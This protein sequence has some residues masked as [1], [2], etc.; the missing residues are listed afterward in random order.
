MTNV[1]ESTFMHAPE[2]AVMHAGFAAEMQSTLVPP[3]T[4]RGAHLEAHGHCVPKEGVGGDLMDLVAEGTDVVAYVGDV[5]GHG[6]RAGVLMGM[7]KTAM[8]Y[9]L[10]LRRA[11]RDLV[12]DLNR[13]LPQVKTPGMYATLAALR[14]DAGDEAEF[15][16]AGHLPLLHFRKQTGDVVRHYAQQPP[17]G[18]LADAVAT[19]ARI[20]IAAG[21]ILLLMSDGAAELGEERD[22][23]A[24]IEVLA[25][26]L[27]DSQDGSL[28]EVLKALETRIAS[29]GAPHDDRT[30]LLIRVMDTG[31]GRVDFSGEDFRGE[32]EAR[33][34]KV[35]DSL[36]A[37]LADE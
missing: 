2:H 28:E 10:L 34:H 33:W 27:C 23:E 29:Y 16:S 30:L 31:A 18:L 32:L 4:Y 8:R 19:S 13:L 24:G 6:L 3:L 35:L 12:V 22:A 9:G 5:S 20:R 7:I 26:V 14:F 36:A 17:L 1:L 37:D 11:F 25:Q 21:D 15:I